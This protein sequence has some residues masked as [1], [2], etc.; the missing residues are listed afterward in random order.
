MSTFEDDMLP[1]ACDL[2]A[3]PSDQRQAHQQ[4]SEQLFAS[5]EAREEQDDGYLLRFDAA[6]FDQIMRFVAN[7]RR[8]CPF[9]RFTIDLTPANGPIWLSLRGRAGVKDFLIEQLI[10]VAQKSCF[11]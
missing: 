10:I 1:I 7:E 5:I 11:D 4:L 2:T 9:I 6:Q 3:I 8:C